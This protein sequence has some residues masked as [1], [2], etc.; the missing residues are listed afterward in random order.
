MNYKKP[1]WPVDV[2][3]KLAQDIRN[4]HTALEESSY[5]NKGLSNRVVE[6]KFSEL[7]QKLTKIEWALETAIYEG[8]IISDRGKLVITEKGLKT[9]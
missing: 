7:N 4:E 6:E 1:N 2:L 3:L 8:L 5:E 9:L